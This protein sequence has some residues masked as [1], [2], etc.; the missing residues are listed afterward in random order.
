MSKLKTQN[1]KVENF[2][3]RRT[4]FTLLLSLIVVSILLSIGLGIFEVIMRE[5][6]ISSIG[7]ESQIAF[8]AANAGAECA[9]YWDLTTDAF[10]QD[11][12]ITCG[13]FY[14]SKATTD[15]DGN[16]IFSFN[17]G[18]GSGSF[19]KVCVEVKVDKS[20]VLTT[21][22]TTVESRGSNMVCNGSSPIKVQRAIRLNIK[23]T[24]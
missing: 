15:S 5:I 20:E 10:A 17:L 4:G 12:N 2:R 16:K 19:D 14:G 22:I 8:Y 23:K 7:R 9:F 21:G 6:R 13:D 24:E 3:Q 18:T 1:S 11:T